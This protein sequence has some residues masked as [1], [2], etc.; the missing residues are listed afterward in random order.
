MRFSSSL[1][2]T[3]ALAAAGAAIAVVVPAQANVG[4]NVGTEFDTSRPLRN[5]IPVVQLTQGTRNLDLRTRN[6][7]VTCEGV[8]IGDAT[9]TAITECAIQVN[10]ATFTNEQFALP[11]VFSATATFSQLVPVGATVRGC[12][13]VTVRFTDPSATPV[14]RRTCSASQVALA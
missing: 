1:V 7:V 4:A 5:A 2:R 13:T 9:S 12:T 3:V 14:T 11:G 6:V 8:G 10:N